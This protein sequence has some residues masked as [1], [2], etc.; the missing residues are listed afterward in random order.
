[1]LYLSVLKVCCSYLQG[2]FIVLPYLHLSLRSFRCACIFTISV[3]DFR[4]YFSQL[5][6]VSS[7]LNFI[8]AFHYVRTRC[9]LFSP[10]SHL[11]SVVAKV[12]LPCHDKLS[13]FLMVFYN[14]KICL[15]VLPISN[16]AGDL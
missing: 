6:P 1:M 10:P 16:S 4:G 14:W 9:N 2:F 5:F 12:S 15:S 3:F 7:V 13:G 8:L 11:A